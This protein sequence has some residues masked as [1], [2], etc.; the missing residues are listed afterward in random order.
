MYRS[1]LPTP[2]ITVDRT[3]SRNST[4]ETERIESSPP[5]ALQSDSSMSQLNTSV[6]K[7]L[8]MNMG[9]TPR[10]SNFL[11]DDTT[12]HTPF[13][14]KHDIAPAEETATRICE[15]RRCFS[16][17]VP[18]G[19]DENCAGIDRQLVLGIYT[20][21]LSKLSELPE[22]HIQIAA[23]CARKTRVILGIVP[24][25]PDDTVFT[26]AGQLLTLV[27]P[28]Y[29]NPR[30]DSAVDQFGM[31]AHWR[32]NA[33]RDDGW[34]EQY[35]AEAVKKETQRGQRLVDHMGNQ[36][37]TDGKMLEAVY[38]NEEM[39]NEN[40]SR[41]SKENVERKR[42]SEMTAETKGKRG[43]A[44]AES[45]GKSREATSASSS[46]GRRGRS[47]HVILDSEDEEDCG[48]E[49]DDEDNTAMEPDDEDNRTMESDDDDDW[50]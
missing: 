37:M 9:Y 19:G 46:S 42:K 28:Q 8:K 24:A 32:L 22:K 25:D 10:F 15:N 39:W 23:E 30:L 34:P 5:S 14:H 27:E 44:T 17:G 18:L 7:P 33:W 4:E 36:S 31:L 3:S 49:S 40:S 50:T 48:M 38:D 35:P 26:R 12:T 13:V 1:L 20:E 29:A 6:K 2:P 16:G 47:S 43:E 11:E 41:F 45:N 21:A